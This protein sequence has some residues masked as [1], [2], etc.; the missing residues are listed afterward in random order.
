MSNN[1][2]QARRRKE[3]AAAGVVAEDEDQK[4]A[5][6]IQLL[7]VAWN[8]AEWINS[9]GLRPPRTSGPQD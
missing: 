9:A 4:I 2:A 7:A 8:V 6:M 5:G 1:S 3:S